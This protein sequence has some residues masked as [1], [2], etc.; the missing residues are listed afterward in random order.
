MRVGPKSERNREIYEARQNGETYASMSVRY[1]VSPSRVAVICNDYKRALKYS[2]A[3]KESE[4]Y[5]VVVKG[6]VSSICIK[7]VD[8]A[9]ENA[10]SDL[11][12][13]RNVGSEKA[14]RVKLSEQKVIFKSGSLEEAECFVDSVLDAVSEEKDRHEAAMRQILGG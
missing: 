5:M 3:P 1:G 12:L 4:K 8:R 2:S 10:I 7:E 14:S 13:W 6:G 11:V 9:K